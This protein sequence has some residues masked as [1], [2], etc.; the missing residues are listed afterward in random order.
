MSGTSLWHP[1]STGKVTPEPALLGR[2]GPGTSAPVIVTCGPRQVLSEN[3]NVLVPPLKVT[4][5]VKLIVVPQTNEF[6]VLTAK[7]TAFPPVAFSLMFGY[8]EFGCVIVTP[9]VVEDKV[10]ATFWPRAQPSFRMVTLTLLH[11]FASMM[12]LPFPPETVTAAL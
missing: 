11:S 1:A 6:E 3:G 12:P 7:G 10:A 8:G 2:I 5:R 9:G 4:V